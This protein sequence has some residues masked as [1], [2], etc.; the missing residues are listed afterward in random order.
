MVTLPPLAVMTA[1]CVPVSPI[2]TLPKLSAVGVMLNCP[3]VAVVPVP[4][5]GRFRAGPDTK[6]LPPASPAAVGLNVTLR[7]TLCPGPSD[8][9]TAGPL[10]ENSLPK[11]WNP[12]NVCAWLC[13]FVRTMGRVALDPTDVCAK[14][15]LNGLAINS[16]VLTPDPASHKGM[17]GFDA[18]PVNNTFPSVHPVHPVAVGAKVTLSV[19]LSPAAR[20]AGRVIPETLNSVPP[21]LIAETVV[22]VSPVLVKIISRVSVSP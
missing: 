1:A 17:L 22:A 9:G 21:A 15:R 18:L 3:A 16:S 6:T 5:R 4:V 14:D 20:D 12:C 7:V 13:E 11:A 8:I 2:I 19:T 10:T